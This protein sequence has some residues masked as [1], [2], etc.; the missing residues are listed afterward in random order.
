M[1]GSLPAQPEATGQTRMTKATRIDTG[2]AVGCFPD[3]TL[4]DALARLIDEDDGH[5]TGIKIIGKTPIPGELE[6]PVAKFVGREIE[7]TT[8]KADSST[9]TVRVKITLA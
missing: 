7:V 9:K 3:Q 5:P 8:T 6:R 2:K 4:A 1:A